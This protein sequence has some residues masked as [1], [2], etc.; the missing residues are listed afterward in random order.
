MDIKNNGSACKRIKGFT[1]VELVVV[2]AIIAILAGVMNLATQGFIRSSRRESANDNA[3]LLF[4]GFQNIV[5]QCEIKQDNTV[6]S[7]SFAN[8]TTL[9]SIVI[10]LKIY[11]GN[12][13]K[14]DINGTSTVYGTDYTGNSFKYSDAVSGSNKSKLPNEIMGIIDNTF[15]GEVK[16]YIDYANFEVKSV[17][18]KP[19]L[20]A[21]RNTT[22][23]D[24]SDGNLSTY[25]SG[26]VS[27]LTYF[28]GSAQ[29]TAYDN[30]PLYG[31]YPFQANLT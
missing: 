11:D 7:P 5:T 3:R 21:N 4:T 14:I 12:V 22:I 31:V 30:H 18:Y 20:E 27:Y 8:D 2:M 24:F 17:V 25:S 16:V 19:M 10:S 13:Q 9:T 23:N 15:E 28:D 6:I 26:G 29:E 1:L